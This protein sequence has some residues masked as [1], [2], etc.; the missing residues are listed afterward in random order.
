MLHPDDKCEPIFLKHISRRDF[1]PILTA[2]L[3]ILFNPH[4]VVTYYPFELNEGENVIFHVLNMAEGSLHRFDFAQS[5][6]IFQ[7]DL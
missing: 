5:D 4:D 3:L 6:F 1:P 2:A 7:V